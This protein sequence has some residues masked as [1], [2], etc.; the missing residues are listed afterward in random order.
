MG[1]SPH[2]PHDCDENLRPSSTAATTMEDELPP[3]VLD[4]QLESQFPKNRVVVHVY[5]DGN[6]VP[7]RWKSERRPIGSG[8]QGTVYLQTCT[9]GIRRYTQRVVKMI[10]LQETSRR[11]HY[12]RELR[13]VAR[14]S[15]DRV[16]AAFGEQWIIGPALMY[17]TS[18]RDTL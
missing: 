7:E 8:G 6:S 18:I 12:L 4:Y 14:F 17:T 9:D 3:E 13:I 2:H 1:F 11:R 5:D 16:C 10:P 15:H